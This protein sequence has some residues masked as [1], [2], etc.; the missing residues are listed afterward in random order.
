MKTDWR[1]KATLAHLIAAGGE[2]VGATAD[3]ACAVWCSVTAT[4]APIIST[5]ELA[6]LYRRSLFLMRSR[7]PDLLTAYEEIDGHADLIALQKVL[8]NQTGTNA[9]ETN[10]ALIC[11][12]YDLL[13]SLIGDSLTDQLLNSALDHHFMG[14][15]LME[16]VSDEARPDYSG[17]DSDEATS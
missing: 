2:S 4:L 1:I 9:E 13:S 16:L 3:A 8:S 14:K 17:S 5:Y 15:R 11:T 12:F 6:C 7:F 10:I